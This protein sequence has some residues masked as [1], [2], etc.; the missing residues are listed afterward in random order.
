[1]RNLA[2]RT[3]PGSE[4]RRRNRKKYHIPAEWLQ[5]A[6]AGMNEVL[7]R[8][9]LSMG[10]SRPLTGSRLLSANTSQ[11]Y[12]KHYRGLRYFCCMIGDYE[13]LIFL[14]D[15]APSHYCPAMS[16]ITISNFIRFKRG[17]AES[18]LISANGEPVLDRNGAAALCQGGWNDPDNATQFLSAVSALHASRGQRGQYSD[19]CN[20]CWEAKSQT[21]CT[22]GCFHHLGTPRFWRTGDPALSEIVANTKKSSTRDGI[23]YQAKGNFALMINELLE[24]RKGLVSTGSLY[25][26]GVWLMTLLGV[27][28]FLRSDE[29]V[30]LCLE[31]FILDLTA[32]D[33]LG[34]V[35]K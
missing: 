12:Q 17:E 30:E 33:D 22:N 23:G 15:D 18:V 28:L 3:L 32:F 34:R 27:H 6:R 7:V 19:K 35:D 10:N 9:R 5:E 29:M 14:Q 8:L 24:I 31:H 4:F 26:Y 13:S 16:A 11:A 25:D 2:A 1:M 20:A 21:D